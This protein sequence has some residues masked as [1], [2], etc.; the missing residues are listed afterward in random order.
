MKLRFTTS[1]TANQFFFIANLSEWHF[2]CRL[3]YNQ[4]WIEK[5]GALSNEEKKEL[6]VFSN[7]LQKYGFV[8][9]KN[10]KIKYIGKFFYCYPEKK[11]WEEL[12]KNI[13]Q[14]EF[15]EIRN[16]FKVFK[17]RF[18][19]I[20]KPQ[21]LKKRI[22]TVRDLTNKKSWKLL[23]QHIR[24]LFGSSASTK[25]LFVIVLLSPLAGKGVTVAGSA[26]IG[27]RHITY[28]IPKLKKEGWE[29]SY[30]AGILAHEIAH[31]LFS[32]KGGEKEIAKI[33]KK[34]GM[35]SRARGFPMST[36]SIINEAITESFI[37]VGYLGQKYAGN[38]LAP[39]LLGNADKGWLAEENM[40]KEK[41]VDYRNIRKYL[42]WRLYPL[43]VMYGRQIKPV[44]GYFIKQAVL[45]LKNAL[46][47]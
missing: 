40:K 32:K 33:I 39:L 17:K 37:P 21:E 28:E 35:P 30:S 18:K 9:D 6:R 8:Y 1:K 13:T 29:Q 26:N 16:V 12:K 46:G 3:D 31:S 7:I 43:A 42:M 45:S 34:E 14:K 25:E 2:S 20:W 10:G 11:A 5:T 36:V 15:L 24:V 4:K 47:K 38:N 41:G 23:M 19:K 22:K 27:N 44:D